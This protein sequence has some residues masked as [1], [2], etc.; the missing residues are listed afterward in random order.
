MLSV[1]KLISFSR[2][3]ILCKN[4]SIEKISDISKMKYKESF[5]K[6]NMFYILIIWYLTNK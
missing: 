5:D 3:K 2:V 4:K 6:E 1:I